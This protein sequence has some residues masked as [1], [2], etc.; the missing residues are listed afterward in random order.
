[1]ELGNDNHLFND[2]DWNNVIMHEN[3]TDNLF[4]ETYFLITGT[5]NIP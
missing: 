2:I 3:K 5:V 4:E 1:M